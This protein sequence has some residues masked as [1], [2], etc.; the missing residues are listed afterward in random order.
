MNERA[1]SSDDLISLERCRQIL[2]PDCD[3]SDAALEVVRADLRLLAE[4]V[5]AM[6][7]ESGKIAVF[8]G[9]A[10]ARPSG[11]RTAT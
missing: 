11:G 8:D 4:I 9:A 3:L 2:G 10:E 5:V 7:M 6:Y 1:G